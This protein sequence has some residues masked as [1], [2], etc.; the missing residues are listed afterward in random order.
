MHGWVKGWAR[1]AGLKMRKRG[2]EEEEGK[3]TTTNTNIRN[4]SECFR[5][6]RR[7]AEEKPKAR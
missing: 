6:R 7:K 2:K 3:K 5:P 4:I 1:G